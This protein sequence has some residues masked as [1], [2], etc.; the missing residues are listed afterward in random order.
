[1]LYFVDQTDAGKIS[2]HINTTVF[3]KLEYLD[4]ANLVEI[5][6][7][8][9]RIII[10]NLIKIGFLILERSKILLLKFVHCFLHKF[11][12]RNGYC[13]LECDID[14]L[15]V[16]LAAKDIFPLVPI[17]LRGD[18]ESEYPEWFAVDYCP[19]HSREFFYARYTGQ[20]WDSSACAKCD[21]ATA[22]DVR[23]VGKFHLE[24][25]ADGLSYFCCKLT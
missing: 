19:D 23:T 24:C 6:S 12:P 20:E 10:D 13:L 15:Y 11:L 25:K 8:K 5:E 4:Q 21:Q 9:K 7:F 2:S 17:E 16:A 14:S 22:Y 1:M 18:F 3:R